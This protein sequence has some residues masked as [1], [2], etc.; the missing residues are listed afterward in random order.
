[1]MLTKVIREDA[2]ADKYGIKDKG[3]W[4]LRFCYD[5]LYPSTMSAIG[6]I[7]K[8]RQS[9]S[10]EDDPESINKLLR[11]WADLGHGLESD[12]Q[13]AKKVIHDVL[14][15]NIALKTRKRVIYLEK[16]WQLMQ[17]VSML[18]NGCSILGKFINGDTDD[19]P[20]PWGGKE[21]RACQ[22]TVLDCV[23]SFIAIRNAKFPL[24]KLLLKKGDFHK[25]T[26]CEVMI[27]QIFGQAI[28]RPK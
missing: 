5:T 20:Y 1:M 24:K 27:R 28:S 22:D 21:L 7:L 10:V 12:L 15:G 19:N 4:F 26:V 6:S 8:Y 13:Q 25:S 16:L 9:Y 2:H 23:A 14:Q 17:Q 11:G 18:E 3:D